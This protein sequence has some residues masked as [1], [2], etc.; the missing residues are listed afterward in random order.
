MQIC[1]DLSVFNALKIQILYNRCQKKYVKIVL[2]K[3]R[4]CKINIKMNSFCL[5]GIYNENILMNKKEKL[6]II[7]ISVISMSKTIKMKFK[8]KKKFTYYI[9]KRKIEKKKHLAALKN[10]YIKN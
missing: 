2:C 7:E 10:I 9:L 5:K 8:V 3:Q 4:N 1:F 6:K